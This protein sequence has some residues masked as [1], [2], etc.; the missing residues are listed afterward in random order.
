MDDQIPSKIDLRYAES[1]VIFS[2]CDCSLNKDYCFNRLSREDTKKFLKKLRHIEKMTWKQLVSL[3]R[4][5]GL[6]PEKIG[7]ESFNMIGEQDCSE[8]NLVGEQYY[9]HFRV[10]EKG[11]FRV[12]GYQ[13]GQ[14]F[15]ITHIDPSGKIH[16]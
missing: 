2:I 1:K 11:L 3:P 12:F 15:C 16:H 8:Q 7:S 5:S 9:F 10:E 13:K 6:T 14:L 4:E